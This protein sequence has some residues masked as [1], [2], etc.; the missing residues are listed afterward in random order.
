MQSIYSESTA[1][2]QQQT[3]LPLVAE[4]SLLNKADNMILSALF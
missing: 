2:P 4:A 3:P 1:A